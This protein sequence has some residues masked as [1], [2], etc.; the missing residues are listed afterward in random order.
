MT[1][2]IIVTGVL[3]L[4]V[5]AVAL[6]ACDALLAI[7]D[8]A[9]HLDDASLGGVGLDAGAT[10]AATDRTTP[11]PDTSDDARSEDGN[12]PADGAKVVDANA[13]DDVKVDD[14]AISDTGADPPDAEAGTVSSSSSGF[15]S[16]NPFGATAL[17]FADVTGDGRA[18][19]I[20][21]GAAT[22]VVWPSDGTRFVANDGSWLDAGL[23]V[24]ETSF[25]DVT[26]DGR[27]D[28]IE[29]LL[30]GVYV[31][32]ALG[33][34]FGPGTVWAPSASEG[35]YAPNGCSNTQFA[36]VD[37]DGRS[38]LLAIDATGV[39]VSLSTGKAFVD[40]GNWT[41]LPWV[42]DVDTAFARV[43]GSPRSDTI[44][45]NHDG[46]HSLPSTGHSFE[47]NSDG[48][49]SAPQTNYAEAW[50][51]GYFA[52]PLGTYF[53]DVSGDG[54][55]DAIAVGSVGVNVLLSNGSTFVFPPLATTFPQWAAANLTGATSVA[56]A[57]VNADKCA[58]FIAVYQGGVVVQLSN[59][60]DAFVSSSP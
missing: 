60:T 46:V 43:R 32:P 47:W 10:D 30:A 29:T 44:V 12:A 58:D 13:S 36:D 54:K 18:D 35:D 37:G 28:A 53:V 45:V 55:A 3:S 49:V 57:D 31:F 27:A 42:G 7:Q 9:G 6:N 24:S 5:G 40:A 38:D 14:G 50:T 56:F 15:W 17:F 23:S 59:C 34:S 19:L 22:V 1:R 16:A 21:T 8:P 48:S 25:S 33:A 52:G 20:G 11:G 41:V 26:G 39:N 4:S 51:N 2:R